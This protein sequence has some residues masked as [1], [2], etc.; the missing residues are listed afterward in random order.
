M[1]CGNIAL[2]ITRCDMDSKSRKQRV[3]DGLQKTEGII[4]S[5]L[6]KISNGQCNDVPMYTFGEENFKD[7]TFNFLASL[8]DENNTFYEKEICKKIRSP[9][10]ALY[11]DLK[12]KVKQHKK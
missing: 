6:Q 8:R 9:I 5:F 11:E 10:N 1:D 12:R 7:S 2:F 3:T 4:R